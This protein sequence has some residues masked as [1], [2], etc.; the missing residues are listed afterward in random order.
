MIG[1]IKFE[2]ETQLHLLHIKF[3]IMKSLKI[4]AFSALTFAMISCG[5]DKKDNTI[6]TADAALDERK[7]RA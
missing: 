1:V 3:N 5:G 6:P 2:F 4:L 7:A